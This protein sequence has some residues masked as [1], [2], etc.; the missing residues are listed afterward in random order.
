MPW[1]GQNNKATAQPACWP[2]PERQS[3]RFGASL[4]LSPAAARITL[5]YLRAASRYGIGSQPGLQASIH[6]PC[7]AGVDSILW[8]KAHI[9]HHLHSPGHTRRR[10]MLGALGAIGGASVLGCVGQDGG[11]DSST[12]TTSTSSTTTS[13]NLSGCVLIPEETQGPYP[14]N[15]SANAAYFRQDIT[16]GKSGTPLRL[17]LT[18]LN[19]GS[20]CAPVSNARV[21]IWH[22]DKDGVY[23]GYNQPGANT[24][25]QTFC[26]GIQLSDTNGQVSFTTIYPGWYAGRITHIHFQVFLNNGLVATSQIAFPDVITQ[27]VYN[28]SLY[29]AKGQNTS[30]RSF[31]AD[32]VFADGTQYQMCS[33]ATNSATGGYD[34]ELTVGIYA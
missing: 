20:K 21:D 33:I 8:S 30:V 23:S 17:K 22:C 19:F 7:R 16:E 34:A 9:L 4:R 27:A 28:T 24:V 31:A 10:I 26:R 5:R 29:L 18:L 15:L 2:A 6:A 3:A 1:V 11:S 14:L 13:S 32:N 25:G 12:A